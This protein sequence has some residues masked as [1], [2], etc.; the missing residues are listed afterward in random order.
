MRSMM[1]V[2]LFA[3][4]IGVAGAQ[5]P[6]AGRGGRGGGGG[7]GGAQTMTLITTAWPDGGMIPLRY[8]QAGPEVSP[9]I[10][11][12]GAPQGVVSFVLIFHDAD[13]VVN[14]STDDTLHWMLW[15]IPGTA[16][17][18]AQDRPDG[19]EMPDGIRQ[20]SA[21]GSRYRGP[22]A[23]ASG[24]VH[25]YVMELYALDTMLDIK[26]NAQGPQEANPNVQAIRTSIMQ[27][28]VG[29]IRGK[30][31]YLGLFHRPQ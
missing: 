7:R 5:T 12:S 8:T 18:V 20:I 27:A 21:S 22:G 1:V 14:N 17:G 28:M 6:P 16:T 2:T 13:T 4:L 26:V 19:F 31:A 11:W 10:Q 24:P 3:A 29:H 15:N 9:A 23:P 25:H 30:A